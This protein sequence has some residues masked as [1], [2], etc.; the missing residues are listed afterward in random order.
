MEF[1]EKLDPLKKNE[2]V[3]NRYAHICITL[4]EEETEAELV[5]TDYIQLDL[6]YEDLSKF[7]V[8]YILSVDELKSA[9]ENGLQNAYSEYGMYIYKISEKNY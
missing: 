7:D 3:Y 8:E 4:T 5:N 9:D 2:E 6:N 1:W